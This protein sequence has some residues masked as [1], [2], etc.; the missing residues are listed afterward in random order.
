MEEA[1]ENLVEIARE[2]ELKVEPDDV[3][4]WLQSHDRV[5]IHEELFL[6][7]EQRKCFFEMESTFEKNHV[8]I[9]EMTAKD[10]ENYVTLVDKMT[11]RLERI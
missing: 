3:T 4:E 9:V 10:L 5:L 1:A 8:K 2:L 7:D 6:L 11:A